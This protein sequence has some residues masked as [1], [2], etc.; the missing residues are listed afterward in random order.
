VKQPKPFERDANDALGT[1]HRPGATKGSSFV[2]AN[3]TTEVIPNRRTTEVARHPG[4][5]AI[6]PRAAP[7]SDPSLRTVAMTVKNYF[8]DGFHFFRP[9]IHMRV[10][11][12]KNARQP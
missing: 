5:G 11:D 12:G 3:E 8:Q 6:R 10:P 9:L 2:R 7:S 1:G 4:W